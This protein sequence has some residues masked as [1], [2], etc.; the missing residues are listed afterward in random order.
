MKQ[1]LAG[2]VFHYDRHYFDHLA[3]LCSLLDIPLLT[4]DKKSKKELLENYPKLIVRAYEIETSPQEILKDGFTELL[5]CLPR[6]LLEEFFFFDLQLQQ[7][8]LL[9]IWTSH[10]MSDKSTF[11]N[12]FEGLI[13]EEIILYYGPLLKK[14]LLESLLKDKT[15]IPTGNYRQ[16]YY[17]THRKYYLKMIEKSFGGIDHSMRTLLFT[18][19]WDDVEHLGTSVQEILTLIK[20]LPDNYFL[21]LQLHPNTQRQH[22]IAY[23]KL[24]EVAGEKPNLYLSEATLIYP[25]LDFVDVVLSDYSSV[26]YDAIALEKPLF[27]IKKHQEAYTHRACHV[28]LLRDI[29]LTFHTINQTLGTADLKMWREKKAIHSQTFGELPTKAQLKSQ[30]LGGIEAYKQSHPLYL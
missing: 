10:G 25:L 7:K 9:T 19:T 17:Q 21:I 8:R 11:N 24:K 29:H 6:P 14:R 23:E 12:Y 5:T 1:E 2:F 20:H 26:V 15:M 27:V 4:T 28:I 30:I 18:P 16:L 3:P 22:P 13:H